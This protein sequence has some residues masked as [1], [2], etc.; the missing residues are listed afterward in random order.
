[1]SLW[2]EVDEDGRILRR[3]DEVASL[4]A[5]ISPPIE[6]LAR[7]LAWRTDLRAAIGRRAGVVRFG[8]G[9]GQ[10]RVTFDA[11]VSEGAQGARLVLEVVES[12]PDG[13]LGGLFLAHAEQ[14]PDGWL[15]TDPDGVIV[16]CNEG[17]AA[18]VGFDAQG[19]VGRPRRLFRSPTVSMR[20]V[21]TYWR[22]LYAQGSHRGPWAL[23]RS[24]G[25]D[26][27]VHQSVTSARD[28]D[29]RTTHY[30]CTFRDET[31]ERELERIQRTDFAINLLGR[32]CG[33][34]AHAVNNLAGEIVAV[35]DRALLSDDPASA[36]AALDRVSRLG[37]A[38]GE[39]GRRMLGLSSVTAGA[40]P[41]D[42]GR[43]A[44]DLGALL[45]CA[46]GEGGQPV[47][48]S[49]PEQGPRVDCAPDALVRAAVHLVMRSLDGVEGHAG[50]SISA[51]ET[52]ADGELRIEYAATSGERS[53]LRR[54]LPDHGVTDP[55]GNELLTRTYGAGARIAMEEEGDGRVA[56]CVRAPLAP[57]EVPAAHPPRP[58]Q[59]GRWER[60]LIA[61]DNA[62]LRELMA[63][64]LGPLFVEVHEVGDG[65]AAIQRIAELEGRVDLVLV[66]LRMPTRNGLDVVTE[67]RSRWPAVPTIVASGA[68][69]EGVA[70][71]AKA[72][73]ARAVLQK[74]FKLHELRAI[75]RSVLAGAQW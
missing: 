20:E 40:G 16:W 19:I 5:S 29:G 70:Q 71:T 65:D 32:T 62:P 31:R 12:I 63:N 66:D 69:P 11:V 56:V 7:P 38:L 23:R 52:G 36:G 57:P 18:M 64:A 47:R 27:H 44:R 14:H 21:E 4:F 74:P 24:D 15:I 13:A 55:V 10:G 45:A 59:E 73:G 50:I 60:L 51:R 9:R 17:F 22:S 30:I 68:A 58:E 43:V 41:T 33:D 54:L 2:L 49:A 53:A 37:V 34:N 72:A 61:E 35:C 1:M 8:V 67:M 6:D 39:L 48:V 26:V 28:T 75:V 46:A 3:S 42:M 25:V